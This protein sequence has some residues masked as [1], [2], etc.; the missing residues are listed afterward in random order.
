MLKGDS[1]KMFEVVLRQEL[2]VLAIVRG[3]GCKPFPPF[4]RGAQ[5]G[6]TCLEGGRAQ[7]VS[8]PR[9][10][11]PHPL[12]IIDQSLTKV[13]M[14]NRAAKYSDLV[15]HSRFLLQSRLKMLNV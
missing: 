14:S 11:S 10:C 5:K 3:R 2:E 7:K 4:K 6:L 9:F 12:P 8:D 1:T 15:R 13:D